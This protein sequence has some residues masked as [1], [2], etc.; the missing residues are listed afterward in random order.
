MSDQRAKAERLRELHR[1]GKILV[2]VNAWDGVSA[3]IVEQLGYP[4]VA[5]TSAGVAWTEGFADGEEIGREEMLARVSVM[6]R[7]VSVPVS[8]D[9]EGGYGPSV[10]DA[11][12][13]AH[14]AIDAG[15]VGLNF[16]DADAKSVGDLLDAGRQ[17]E[18]VAAIRRVGLD[19]G[20]PLVINA[21]TDC[22]LAGIGSDDR[23]RLEE[24]VRRSNLYL[25]AGADCAFVPGV[26]DEPTIAE[27]VSR[28][29]GP[30][31]IL[32]SAAAPSLARLEQVGVA[33]VSLGSGSI[34]FA[35]AKLRE[36]ASGLQSSG[37]FERLK[38]RLSHAE[39]NALFNR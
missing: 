6:A 24:S 17:A 5:S 15:A 32:A 27:L 21:R 33:R 13:T 12:A 8:A 29:N 25:A 23:Y 1:G 18:R 2:L 38:E 28:I 10:A 39:L 36:L 35:L 11:E 26:S 19:R 7:A 16:E 34:G 14:G 20:V 4:A 3:R 9:L 37:G 30:V 31:N 22:F